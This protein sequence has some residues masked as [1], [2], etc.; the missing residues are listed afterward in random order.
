MRLTAV[1][2]TLGLCLLVLGVAMVVPV[3][4]ALGE[5]EPELAWIFLG[6]A[7]AT[8]FAGGCLVIALQG[9]RRG[10]GVR[11]AILLLVLAWSVLPLFAMLPLLLTNH[12]GSLIAAYFETVSAL[13]T[14]G[15]TQYHAVPEVPISIILWRSVLHWIGGFGGLLVAA[16]VLTG[17]TPTA[18]PVQS[19]IVP[20]LERGALLARMVP[21]AKV[22]APAYVLLTLII[23]VG[24]LIAGLPAFDAICLG[25]SVL[26]TGGVSA[27]GADISVY[28]L[29]LVEAVVMFGMMLGALSFATHTTALRGKWRAYTTDPEAVWLMGI[30]VAAV[31]ALLIFGLETEAW[32]SA[33]TA[34]ALVTTSG[35]VHGDAIG[36]FPPALIFTLVLLG[37]S[38]VSTAGG[39]KMMR[40]I[41]LWKQSQ[42]E[43]TRLARPH[44]ISKLEVL[45]RP[46]TGRMLEPVWVYLVALMTA[47]TFL[48]LILSFSLPNFELAAGAA[49]AALSN[50]GPAF[51][52]AFPDAAGYGEFPPAA[53]LAM[54]VG[55]ILGRIEVLAVPILLTGLFW[56]Y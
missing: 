2:Y 11:E 9:E 17:V 36:G 6:S 42:R 7:L 48:A 31:I 15:A 49:V 38:I 18:L 50:T 53:L 33:F 40:L 4:V 41:L 51:H 19:V 52:M 55:M 35:Y 24:L 16:A 12:P 43:I 29:G 32:P 45:G 8:G 21:L 44:S 30:V 10:S 54:C 37:G 27:Q 13:T 26:A 20:H 22:L 28:G 5:G 56:R 23:V 14:T 1:F 3:P 47:I 46:V 25:F 34:M 39:I